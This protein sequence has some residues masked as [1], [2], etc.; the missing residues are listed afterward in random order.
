MQGPVL[1][2]GR[3]F[4]VAA[5]LVGLSTVVPGD[6]GAAQ[7]KDEQKCTNA[8]NK[9]LQKIAS[10]EGKDI[11][12][13]V[14]NFAKVKTADLGPPGKQTAEE[15]QTND[16]KGKVAKAI[17]KME[18]NFAKKCPS[19]PPFGVTDPNVI[20]AQAV[21]KELGIIDDVM[22]EDLDAALIREA[23]NKDASKCQQAVIKSMFKCQEAQM[24]SFNTC[25]KDGLKNNTILS[26][27]ELAECLDEDS[28]GKI[29]KACDPDAGKLRQ[30]INKKCVNQF[31]DL[32]EAFP[33]CDLNPGL[34][35]NNADKLHDC[36]LDAVECHTCVAIQAADGIEDGLACGP[37]ASSIPDSP[38]GYHTGIL[39]PL[40]PNGFPPAFCDSGDREGEFCTDT[41]NHKDC[42]GPINPKARCI[43]E[44]FAALNTELA[45]PQLTL[46]L[47]GALDVNCDLTT[48]PDP[49]TGTVP[50]RCDVV[51]LKV[52]DIRPIGWA[53]FETQGGCP[54]GFMDCDGGMPMDLQQ[55][56]NHNVGSC[57]LGT[58]DPILFPP[59]DPNRIWFEP[60]VGNAE[61]EWLCEQYCDC[62]TDA[63]GPRCALYDNF[64]GGN[65]DFTVLD[66]GCERYCQEGN[67]PD[68]ACD[69]DVDC[70]TGS[71]GGGEPVAHANG[72]F[73]SCVRRTGDPGRPGSINCTAG[74]QINIEDDPPCKFDDGIDDITIFLPVTC[75]PLSTE[76]S[77][78]KINNPNNTPGELAGPLMFGNPGSCQDLSTS[79][80]AGIE[81]LGNIIFWD[82]AIGDLQTQVIARGR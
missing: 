10:T 34:D 31:V 40:D 44:S 38:I 53:C 60:G 45:Q 35:P 14:K 63:S 55:I 1:L 48:P 11:N 6:A 79:V 73:C 78:G 80:V 43:A 70:P 17:V 20:A 57:G 47:T 76:F 21:D 29:A 37:C 46:A 16:V 74:V 27:A 82:S 7:T 13:C 72:C 30:D 65:G 26:S 66:S 61:C 32:A 24:K 28:K 2:L 77:S 12:A 33:G 41:A 75:V 4:L 39:N 19:V 9:D 69:F 68:Q 64:I 52:Q 15:C 49:V 23:N 8:M 54:T 67:R 50:C 25:K 62:F 59:D 81:L 22:G 71:C 56:G 36:V 51:N 5:L 18:Q 3:A 58:N 42:P